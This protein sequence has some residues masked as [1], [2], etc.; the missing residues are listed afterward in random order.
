MTRSR[1]AVAFLV[2]IAI[3]AVAITLV[4]RARFTADLSAFLPQ[5]PTPEQAILIDQVREGPASQLLLVA[6]KNAP[7]AIL[8]TLSRETAKALRADP[9][10]QSVNNG[11]NVTGDR[12][13]RLLFDHRY[14]LS[15]R[16]VPER[17]TTEGLHAALG[18]SLDLLSS[19]A[20]MMLQPLLA[21]DP[22]AELLGLLDAILAGR[23][24]P[25]VG[26]VWV[27]RPKD[28]PPHALMLI[29]TRAA[30]SDVD[31]QQAAIAAVRAAFDAAKAGTPESAARLIVTGPPVFAVDSRNTIE[32]D[33]TRASILGAAGVLLLLGFVYRSARALLLGVIPM[34]TGA[35]CGLAIVAAGFGV[36]HAIT[37]GFGV[38][39]M[40][41][42]VDYAIYLFVQRP[43]E[44]GRRTG[45]WT[46]I[47]FGA[48][49]SAIGFAALIFSGFEGLAQVGVL[50][51]GG[52]L[53]AAA[54]TRWILPHFMPRDFHVRPMPRLGAA[55]RCLTGRSTILRLPL[56]VLAIVAMVVVFLHRDRLWS[57]D[58]ASLSPVPEEALALDGKLR[59]ELGA[60][61]VRDL[62]VVGGPSQE[63]VLQGAERV[64]ATLAPL[65]ADGTLL[66]VDAPS[67]YLPSEATQRAR[68]A[69]LPDGATLRRNFDA[70][71][72]GTPFQRTG[73]DGF[74]EDV[75]RE[76]T[77]ALLGRAD[78]EGT[79]LA[80]GLRAL[81]TERPDPT[82]ATPGRWVALVAL[83]SPQ[84]GDGLPRARVAQAIAGLAAGNDQG[85]PATRTEIRSIDIGLGVKGLYA[86]YLA[87]AVHVAGLGALAI[88]VLL[89]ALL[90][91]PSRLLRVL[92]PLALA[93][94]FVTAIQLAA[95]GPLNLFH[96][97]G[98]LLIV[99][100][101]SNYALFFDRGDGGDA[102]VLTSLLFANLTTV[103]GFGALSVSA[104][105]ILHAIGTTV[106][107]GAF[108][109]LMIA[110]V[111][112]ARKESA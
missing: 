69:A 67:R 76:K 60:P 63:A 21:R 17:F 12:D 23:D 99:A 34:V 84:A 9:R 54:T 49:T 48:I 74:F 93:V 91:S 71:L 50:S 19:S 85:D 104:F 87:G 103:I 3:L 39:L 11:E 77:G 90:R 70:A 102:T 88:V 107:P 42:A 89:A 35:L 78:F 79:S 81:L 98:L 66:G 86:G 38:T 18:D 94:L 51:I 44:H 109:A 13:R 100:V 8:A 29:E 5:H 20:G 32:R 56:I 2:W 73:F 111:F 80:L 45:F 41:E 68:Q 1:R 7:D 110:A 6:I 14:L 37:L 65:V 40:G 26:G 72:E 52:L 101:G 47:A 46:T 10:F 112:A 83:R 106:A 28:E 75:A 97:V 30:G 33:A 27:A 92:A 57:D 22:T 61:D 59:G 64:V 108:L 82:G 55:L 43:D 4:V 15:E 24:L 16:T 96:L 53:V 31:A 58:L 105:P 25:T 36:V 62:V 95:S